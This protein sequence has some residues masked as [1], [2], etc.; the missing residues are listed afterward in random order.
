MPKVPKPKPNAKGKGASHTT[1]GADKHPRCHS[2]FN[3]K[4]QSCREADTKVQRLAFTAK[5]RQDQL[6]L[7]AWAT[8][9]LFTGTSIA[10]ETAADALQQ[11]ADTEWV[12]AENAFVPAPIAPGSAANCDKCF[13][14][15]DAR[16]NRPVL[17][18]CGHIACQT[19]TRS[20]ASTGS[21]ED[22]FKCKRHT[23]YVVPLDPLELCSTSAE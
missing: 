19:C 4:C 12:S 2:H 21:T 22:C 18:E 9:C 16:Q 5:R 23:P 14:P 20:S 6:H 1:Y 3:F 17:R 15:F 10:A 8:A 11:L 7:H 13:Q